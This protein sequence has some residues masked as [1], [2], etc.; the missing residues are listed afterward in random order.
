M[1]QWRKKKN[2][3]YVTYTALCNISM[4]MSLIYLIQHGTQSAY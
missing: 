3:K 4:M 1:K 2:R